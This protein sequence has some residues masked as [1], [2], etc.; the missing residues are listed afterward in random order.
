MLLPIL[1]GQ[2][3]IGPQSIGLLALVLRQLGD[4]RPDHLVRLA[5]VE[6]EVE[7]SE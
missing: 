2:A 3:I 1:C 4:G 6:V 5:K 7:L